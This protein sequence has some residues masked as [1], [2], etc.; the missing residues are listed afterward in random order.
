MHKDTPLR[1]QRTTYN[2]VVGTGLDAAPWLRHMALRGTADEIKAGPHRSS[3][4]RAKI[5]VH[6]A[7][8]TWP[9]RA[10]VVVV[11]AD[12]SEAADSKMGATSNGHVV[13]SAPPVFE[14][15][16]LNSPLPETKSSQRSTDLQLA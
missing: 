7:Q 9:C 8:A 1:V 3:S 16:Q 5:C 4:K 6:C 14:G 10:S 13:T 11:I 2:A 15:G 12:F